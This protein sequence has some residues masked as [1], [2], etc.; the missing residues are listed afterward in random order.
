MLKIS[1]DENFP[2]NTRALPLALIVEVKNNYNGLRFA[3]L[4]SIR[5]LSFTLVGCVKDYIIF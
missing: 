1:F 5:F 4:V 2:E 3:V